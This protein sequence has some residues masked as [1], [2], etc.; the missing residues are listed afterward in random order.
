MD[1][2]CMKVLESGR[3]KL[4][5]FVCFAVLA[6]T[7]FP[8]LAEDSASGGTTASAWDAAK[9]SAPLRSILEALPKAPSRPL[10]KPLEPLL[11]I[12]SCLA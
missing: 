3:K 10:L 11:F 7:A 5:A 8:A 1:I 2:W 9:T 6:L 4:M 12:C